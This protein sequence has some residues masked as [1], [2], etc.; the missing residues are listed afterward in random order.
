[1]GGGRF[2][3]SDHTGPRTHPASYRVGT[4]SFLGVKRP[5]RGI[6]HPPPSS[7]EV[8]EREELYL[9]SPSGPSW[10]VLGW[11]LHFTAAQLHDTYT[12]FTPVLCCYVSHDGTAH[13][14]L[15]IVVSP[16]TIKLSRLQSQD[17]ELKIT[18]RVIHRSRHWSC[19][20]PV[21]CTLLRK[22]DR[23]AKLSA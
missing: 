19:D 2:S 20:V 5:G 18:F 4:G 7:A 22:A 3:A 14:A 21:E 12:L 8:K 6:D 11:T 13:P 1:M 15:S 10:P 17:N 23:S 16:V 9:Y